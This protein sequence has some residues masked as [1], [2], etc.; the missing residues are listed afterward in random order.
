MFMLLVNEKF[1]KTNNSDAIK[2]IRDMI[3]MVGDA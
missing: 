3:G 1:F 2:S